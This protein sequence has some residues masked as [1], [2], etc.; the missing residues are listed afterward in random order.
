MCRD[1]SFGRS[2]PPE[3][4]R[5][6]AH[7]PCDHARSARQKKGEIPVRALVIALCGCALSTMAHAQDPAALD[8]AAG[9]IS[10]CILEQTAVEL[11]KST[12]PERF[13]GIL[14]ERCR[15]EERH[16]RN[17]LIRGAKKE[18][19]LDRRILRAIEEFLTSLRRQ[20]VIDYADALHERQEAPR[21]KFDRTV[22]RQGPSTA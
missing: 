4:F 14:K 17:T 20:S 22:L 11:E 5:R 6:D 16:F 9:R 18:G 13:E 10:Q 12:A 21:P 15:V 7:C 3:P 2:A 1:G 8:G 19:S